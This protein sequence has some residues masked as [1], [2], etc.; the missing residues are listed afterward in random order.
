MIDELDSAIF[1]SIL[2]RDNHKVIRGESLSKYLES[3]KNQDLEKLLLVGLLVSNIAPNLKS[4]TKKDII[5]QIK[6]N[7]K[8]IV[9]SYIKIS[10]PIF[11]KEFKKIVSKGGYIKSYVSDFDINFGFILYVKQFSLAKVYYDK[12]KQTIEVYIPKGFVDVIKSAL[13]NKKIKDYNKDYNNIISHVDAVTDTYGVITLDKLHDI[14]NEQI[15]E[16]DRDTLTEMLLNSNVTDKPFSYEQYENTDLIYSLSFDNVKDAY[17]FYKK[18]SGEYF[19]FR[20]YEFEEINSGKYLDHL[21]SYKEF[22]DYLIDNYYDFEDEMEDIK[23]LIVKDFLYFA[24]MDLNN[25]IKIF[26]DKMDRTFEIIGSDKKK[27]KLLAKNIFNEYPKWIKH[28][29]I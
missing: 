25:G 3:F 10:E 18:T 14:I 27:L 29:N 22:V 24:Q 12:E 16:V 28:G 6:G 19:D 15:K 9:E 7:L 13:N 4:K 26:I 2:E 23:L 5:K 8:E 21:K 20:K 11:L 1:N 17:E